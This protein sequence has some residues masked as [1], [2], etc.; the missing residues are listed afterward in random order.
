MFS[1]GHLLVRFISACT[2]AFSRCSAN[3]G[4]ATIGTPCTRLSAVEFL[5]Q[6]VRNPPVAL[7]A[8]QC[9]SPPTFS[10]HATKPMQHSPSTFPRHAAQPINGLE[11]CCTEGCYPARLHR[12]FFR[13]GKKNYMQSYCTIPPC[14]TAPLPSIHP[15]RWWILIAL[16]FST[17]V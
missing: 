9:S 7:W 13:G 10:R 16:I 8:T 11:Q 17:Q 3:N 1:I 5:P 14:S 12:N 6:C 2:T 15:H 4:Q